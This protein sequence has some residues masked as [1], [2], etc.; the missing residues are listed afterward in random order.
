MEKERLGTF[1]YVVGGLSFIPLIGIIFGIV[2]IIWGLVTTKI[3]GKKLAFIGMGGIAFTIIIYSSLFY[4]G[5][6]QR[7]G[8]YDDL[9]SKMAESNLV[10]VVQA[11]EFYKVQHGAYPSSLEMVEKSLPK[12]SMVFFFDVT[13]MQINNKPRYYHY[14]LIDENSYYLLGLGTDNQPYTAD[15]LLPNIDLNTSSKVGFRINHSPI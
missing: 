13:D 9:R 8:V 1:P 4:F 3:G 15:D 6:K 7:G 14:K 10:Q 11:I 5:F 2:S 12:N